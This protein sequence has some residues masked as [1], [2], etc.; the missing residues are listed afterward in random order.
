MCE[1]HTLVLASD[2]PCPACLNQALV[3]RIETLTEAL[4]DM[5]E[6]ETAAF[7]AVANTAGERETSECYQEV[8]KATGQGAKALRDRTWIAPA[9]HAPSPRMN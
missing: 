1:D 5:V 8:V 4:S 3:N 9:F 2:R 6:A 7:E